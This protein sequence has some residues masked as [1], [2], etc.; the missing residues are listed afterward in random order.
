M[1]LIESQLWHNE[2]KHDPEKASNRQYFYCD[3]AREIDK[4]RSETINQ[5]HRMEHFFK[6]LDL[7][8][9]QSMQALF[10]QSLQQ[11]KALEK[12]QELTREISKGLEL[13]L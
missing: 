12:Q 6:K 1:A 13:S 9:N 7:S 8:C 5:D 3:Q 11:H 4:N 2:A 10:Q